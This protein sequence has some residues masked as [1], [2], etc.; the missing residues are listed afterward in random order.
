MTTYL[1]AE[2]KYAPWRSAVESS[3]DHALSSSS[4]HSRTFLK[5]VVSAWDS[6]GL[7]GKGGKRGL[8]RIWDRITKPRP[9]IDRFVICEIILCC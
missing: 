5:N 2:D 9:D 7:Q 3:L 6:L 4:A 1:K 8:R